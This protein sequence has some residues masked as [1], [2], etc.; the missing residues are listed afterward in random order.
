MRLVCS[1]IVDTDCTHVQISIETNS[2][3][4]AVVVELPST[5]TPYLGMW[6]LNLESSVCSLK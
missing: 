2:R 3:H 6:N 1:Y 5:N 4:T